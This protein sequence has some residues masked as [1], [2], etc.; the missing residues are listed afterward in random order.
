M[1]QVEHDL[2]V[3]GGGPGGYVAAIRAAQLGLN[4]ACIDENDRFGGTCLRVGCIPSKALL[5]SSH[6]YLEAKEHFGTHGIKTSGVELDLAAMLNAQRQDC[7]SA[8]RRHRYAA[9]TQ[10]SHSL[11]RPR[12]IAGPRHGGGARQRR[13]ESP[14]APSISIGPPAVARP[15]CAVSKKTA[16]TS[17]T[18]RW[19]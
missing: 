2:V 4:T 11:S 3:V 8:D 9:Q 5:E 13:T 15:R 18:A 14:F 12:Q 17:A 1:K 6:L 19:R 7:R 16:C 10:K